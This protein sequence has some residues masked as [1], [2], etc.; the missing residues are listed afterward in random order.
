VKA[1]TGKTFTWDEVLAEGKRRME[2]EE[3]KVAAMTPE[4]KKEYEVEQAKRRAEAEEIL[5]KLRGP[6][7]VEL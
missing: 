3:R 5:K 4:Q 1:I 6:G 2:A 7:F